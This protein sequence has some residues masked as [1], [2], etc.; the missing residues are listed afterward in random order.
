M[1]D[2]VRELCSFEGRLAGTDAERRAANH[3]AARLRRTAHRVDVEPT[4]VHPQWAAVHAL[5]AAM[6]VLPVP[7]TDTLPTAST[8][9]GALV[10]SSS[11]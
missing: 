1:I 10:T 11:P 9:T 6:G 4:Y 3:L 8:G 5:H 7:P 2:D